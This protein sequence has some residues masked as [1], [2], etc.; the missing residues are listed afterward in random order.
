[1]DASAN[2]AFTLIGGDGENRDINGSDV[3]DLVDVGL[4]RKMPPS[5]YEITGAGR[6]VIAAAQN[7]PGAK[8]PIGFG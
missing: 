1:M 8:N 7:P 3:R 6:D 4:V 5:S 2:G